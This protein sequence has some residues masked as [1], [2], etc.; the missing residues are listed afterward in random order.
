MVHEANNSI[1]D[2]VCALRPC[3]AGSS[4]PYW[5]SI[6]KLHKF[7]VIFSLFSRYHRASQAMQIYSTEKVSAVRAVL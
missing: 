7:T 6:E 3:R 2:S 4:L 1:Y 5:F